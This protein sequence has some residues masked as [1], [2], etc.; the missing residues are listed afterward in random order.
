MKIIIENK[1]DTMHGPGLQIRV[2]NDMGV[3]Q[4]IVEQRLPQQPQTAK[5]LLD[6]AKVAR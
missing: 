3:T 2:V 6:A 1:M 5:E 4:E